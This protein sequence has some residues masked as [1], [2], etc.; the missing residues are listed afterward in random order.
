MNADA[1]PC[2]NFKNMKYFTYLEVRGVVVVPVELRQLDAV[3]DV[4]RR[5]PRPSPVRVQ[6]RAE[7]GHA[8]GGEALHGT[9]EFSLG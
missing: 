5:H 1:Q 6:L 9:F 7:D 2:V 8:A 3:P 4:P